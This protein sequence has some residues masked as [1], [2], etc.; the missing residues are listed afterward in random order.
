MASFGKI[1]RSEMIFNLNSFIFATIISTTNFFLV[2]WQNVRKTETLET[3]SSCLAISWLQQW[4]SFSSFTMVTM[5]IF[6]STVMIIELRDQDQMGTSR[7]SWERRWRTGR[8]RGQGLKM[9][10]A[11]RALIFA[12]MEC[13]TRAL[14][15]RNHIKSRALCSDTVLNSYC[16]ELKI[17]PP[18]SFAQLHIVNNEYC[19]DFISCSI[20]QILCLLPPHAPSQHWL[21][22]PGK[23]NSKTFIASFHIFDILWYHKYCIFYHTSLIVVLLPSSSFARCWTSYFCLLTS[24]WPI[25]SWEVAL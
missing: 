13:I 7:C 1:D 22:H 17:V 18:L 20:A 19:A 6:F 16:P 23:K 11:S 2:T 4:S 25:S 21:L 24:I 10:Q 3:I 9:L 12:T 14:I 5:M 8:R 15:F